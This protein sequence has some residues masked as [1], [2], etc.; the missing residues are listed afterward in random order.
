MGEIITISRHA[1][2][3]VV[4]WTPMAGEWR[5]MDAAM[6]ACKK[7]AGRGAEFVS[8]G[9]SQLDGRLI[10]GYRGPAGTFEISRVARR[11]PR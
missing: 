5:A 8:F 2:G 3:D 6:R 7:L 11:D 9:N 10:C 4:A 1:D